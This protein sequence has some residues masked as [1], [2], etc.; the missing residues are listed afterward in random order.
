MTNNESGRKRREPENDERRSQ[1]LKR[2]AEE[3][4][5]EAKVEDANVQRMI[6]RSIKDHGA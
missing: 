5:A 6:E 2:E 1:C 4:R 3:R